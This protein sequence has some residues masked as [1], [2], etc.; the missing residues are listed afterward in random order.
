MPRS[1]RAKVIALTQTQKKTREHKSDFVQ[2][3][4][5]KVEEH[6]SV[7]VFSYEN[8]R[9]NKFKNIRMDFSKGEDSSRIFLGK[10]KLL[11]MALGKTPEDEFRDN[12]RHVSK[13]ISGSV[14]LLITSRND[15]EVKNYFNNFAEE[16]FARAGNIADREVK[17][18]SDMLTV[19]PVNQ[20]E[21]FRKL[22]L[23]VDVNNGK[24]VLIG[25]Q[26]EFVL[27]K[28]GDVLS[29][30]VCKLLVHF[31]LKLAEFRTTLLCR[32][33]NDGTF[34]QLD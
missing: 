22:G 23:P 15:K 17:V 34:E 20:V 8:M 24:M 31:G 18:T 29:A 21:P 19:H 12:L 4:R 28:E 6:E 26:T 1:K 5:E 30:E 13:L 32:W 7:Y 11:Q 33:S 14:G 9:S 3:V 25:G 27:C 2:T 10:N 16:D